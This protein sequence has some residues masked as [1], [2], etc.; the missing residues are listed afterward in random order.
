MATAA[1]RHRDLPTKE[2]I[3]QIQKLIESIDLAAPW[4]EIPKLVEDF[5]IV[6]PRMLAAEHFDDVYYGP[7]SNLGRAIKELRGVI[8]RLKLSGR[9]P[10]E[11]DSE[12]DLIYPALTQSRSR[13]H[14]EALDL[15]C[16]AIASL[17]MAE[18]LSRP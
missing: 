18:F 11:S 3:L 16:T 5:V 9:V 4:L 12:G 10:L 1:P 17:K 2:N 14:Q 6:I 15:C 13:M 8:L 7:G